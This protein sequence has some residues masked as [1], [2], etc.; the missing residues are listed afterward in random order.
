MSTPSWLQ[1][2]NKVCVVTGGAG[3]IGA[4]VGRQLAAAGAKVAL[5]DRNEQ[6]AVE[7]ARSI[8][9]AG[10]MAI[11]VGCDVTAK[12]AVDA[13]AAEV[14]RQ[15]GRCDVLVNNAAAL[16]AAALLDVEIAAWNRVMNVNLNGYLLCTQAF[17]R[18]MVDAG[19]GGSIVHVS[20]LAGHEPQP[21]SGPYSVSKAGVAML[22]RLLAVELGEYR[23][24]SNVVSPAM[25]RTPLSEHMY[26]N[27]EVL[28]IREAIVPAHRISEPRDIAEIVLFLASDRSSYVNGQDILA[29]GGLSA[30]W[31]TLIPRPGWEKKDA[32]R[33]S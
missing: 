29:D 13:A 6:G 27:A 26:S 14:Q 24:R 11:G 1:L 9:A 19:N 12:T 16:H 23:I 3:G 15:F 28:Q 32:Q 21:Y 5:L 4:E 20:S 25:I 8:A 22:S 31:L 33:A 10:G 17:A 7:V 30:A 18:Q 2:E